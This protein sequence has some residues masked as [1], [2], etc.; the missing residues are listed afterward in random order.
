MTELDPWI[1]LTTRLEL[2]RRYW[3]PIEATGSLEGLLA[4]PDFAAAPGKH[5]SLFADH[6]ATHARDV[7]TRILA[8]LD[9]SNGTLFKHRDRA[10]L[11]FMKAFGVWMAYLHDVGMVE[12]T[13]EGRRQHARYAAQ[14]VFRDEF[15]DMI[16]CARAPGPLA[17]RLRQVFGDDPEVIGVRLREL[18][19]MSLCH[20][21]SAM[22]TAR[23]E[24]LP[25]LRQAMTV[26]VCVDL[27]AQQAA[28]AAGG[29]WADASLE[30][31]SEHVDH[32]VASGLDPF[33]WLGAP[34][35]D[36]RALVADVMDTVRALRVADA[37]RQRGRDLR[38]SAG[39][40]VFV[41]D[42]GYAVFHL[43]AASSG[44]AVHLRVDS[45]MSV[46]EANIESA[47]IESRGDLRVVLHRGAFSPEAR[48]R[49]AEACATV[50]ADVAAD[51]LD[52]FPEAPDRQILIENHEDDHT[53]A[54]LVKAAMSAD[55]VYGHR[56]VVVPSLANCSD[57]ERR[58]YFR[59]TPVT[60]PSAHADDLMRAMAGSGLRS[61]LLDTGRCFA[62]VRLAKVDA[63]DVLMHEGGP[64]TFVYIPTLPGLELRPGGGFAARPLGAWRRL[65]ATG[66]LRRGTRNSTIV[67]VEDL[68]VFM[69]PG[70]VYAAQWFRP[71][72]VDDLDEI[73]AL[74]DPC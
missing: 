67:A 68:D 4:D 15:K 14:L 60:W 3:D 28:Q 11:D 40:E 10:S 2:E 26:A 18:L 53:I 56:S 58:R 51:V 23:L 62:G 70:D 38:T 8:V 33:G 59:A 5:L 39:F 36:E 13:H 65:G 35:G 47:T 7:A 31:A 17:D 34:E 1:D 46:G 6:S 22:P 43:A 12:S 21:K 32:Y 73:R 48:K 25:R 9:D 74:V 50:I 29:E 42:T 16:E 57:E 41:D 30:D 71:Y 64:A 45:P 72:G 37:L 55:S 66:V 24:D 49:V 19:A 69:I 27:A 63:G 20:S 52:V 54:H 61:S 44:V